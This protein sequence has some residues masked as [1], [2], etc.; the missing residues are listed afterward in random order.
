[1]TP[2]KSQTSRSTE[3]R[4]VSVGMR[5]RHGDLL[6]VSAYDRVASL[7]VSLL[8]MV[9]VGVGILIIIWI[10][11]RVFTRPV[12]P[13]VYLFEGESIGD[14]GSTRRELSEPG[15][16]ELDLDE[17]NVQLTLAAVTNA[18]STVAAS[19]DVVE[20]AAAQRGR[21]VDNRKGGGGDQIPRWQRWEIRYLDTTLDAYLKQLAFFRIELAAMGGG[22]RRI[23]YVSFRDG[24]PQ[25]RTVSPGED[26]ND[27]RLYF[28]WQAGRF[29]DQDRGLLTRAGLDTTG[30]VIC[31]FY[32]LDVENQLAVLEDR[33]RGDRELREIKQT[34]FGV[35]PSGRKYEFY[36]IEIQW[37]T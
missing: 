2:D 35:R 20:S 18:V 6:R 34:I 33:Q 30:R 10:T 23:D 7:L 11:T 16:D 31:Q 9:G 5:S 12:A 14:E 4:D 36:V 3:A 28:V 15:L 21:G 29:R 27:D 13:D 1:M 8:V 26:E 19:L 17:P 22:L 25:V 32:P 24:R 37:R